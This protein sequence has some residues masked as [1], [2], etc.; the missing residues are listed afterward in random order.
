MLYS[1][2]HY[3]KCVHPVYSLQ[4][5]QIHNF[6][7][8]REKSLA[9]RHKWISQRLSNLVTSNEFSLVGISVPHP[10]KLFRSH[11]VGKSPRN[12]LMSSRVFLNFDKLAYSALLWKQLRNFI[13][14]ILWN[15]MCHLT[16]E[17]YINQTYALNWLRK[18]L[19]N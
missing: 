2:P 7:K 12:S 11:Q 13:F 8:K 14:T 19:Q 4:K 1:V 16:H 18:Q 15:K 6:T 3:N 10:R 17:V 9:W 5:I